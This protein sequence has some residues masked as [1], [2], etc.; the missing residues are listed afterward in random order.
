LVERCQWTK[1][2]FSPVVATFSSA[3]VCSLADLRGLD[4][5]RIPRNAIIYAYVSLAGE[6]SSL[7]EDVLDD[8]EMGRAGRFAFP[9]DRHRFIVSHM[10]LRVLLARCLGLAP[11][12]IAYES[13]P[14]GKPSLA[15]GI[16]PL[17][18]NMS[19][20]G[21]LALVAACRDRAIGVDVERVRDVPDALDIADQHFSVE[22]RMTLRS[23][24]SNERRT[25]F[26]RCWTRKEAVIKAFGEGL[27]YPLD[28][29]DVDLAP[30]STSALRRF[31]GGAG[32]GASLLLRDL[33]PPPGYAAAGA[34]VAP[35]SPPISWQEL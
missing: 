29:F 11:S 12:E 30:A 10:A 26:F 17:Q 34:V 18:F 3:M 19:H 9:Q 25:A 33:T 28:S 6:A 23:L 5:I 8:D 7:D 1:A 24:P 31:D 35:S 20:S 21:E 4:T 2:G 15:D 32:E 16:G 22:E 14:N 13:G 27:G